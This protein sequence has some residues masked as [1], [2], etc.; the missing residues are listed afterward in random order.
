MAVTTTPAKCLN[1]GRKLTAA[2]SIARGRGRTCQA[3]IRAAANVIDLTDYKPAQ[4]ES[5]RELIEDAAI[6]PI[7][8]NIFATVATDGTATYLTAPQACTCPAGLKGRRCY[9][10]AAAAILIAA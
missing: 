1:C 5:A 10:R 8:A 6:I 4:I 7:R 3:K 9:H 2:A